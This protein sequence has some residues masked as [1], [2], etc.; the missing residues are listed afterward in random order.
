[1]ILS[2]MQLRKRS[3][4]AWNGA[5]AELQRLRPFSTILRNL[6]G[7]LFSYGNRKV[8]AVFT[9]THHGTLSWSSWIQS[10][11]IKSVDAMLNNI[12]L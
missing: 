12:S 6:G 8:T 1:M 2:Q 11:S 3:A 10:T 9:K 5:V 4:K 7:Q